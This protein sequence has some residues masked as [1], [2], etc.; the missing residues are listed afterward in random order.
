MR[1][2]WIFGFPE[3]FGNNM[4]IESSHRVNGDSLSR[5]LLVVSLWIFH[6]W[7]K[8]VLFSLESI[9]DASKAWKSPG[10][11][12]DSKVVVHLFHFCILRW[13][14][15]VRFYFHPW[16]WTLLFYFLGSWSFFLILG[17]NF[18]WSR[19][20]VLCRSSCEKEVKLSMHIKDLSGS[21][22]KGLSCVCCRWLAFLETDYWSINSG[23]SIVLKVG[24]LWFLISF[25]PTDLSTCMSMVFHDNGFL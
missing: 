21:I 3:Y 15:Q 11:L 5:V 2:L 19:L 6:I 20:A 12:S 22:V 17:D 9:Y 14:L 10:F 18:S 13:N 23:L 7:S 4:T 25:H 1:R 24:R 16:T 8:K